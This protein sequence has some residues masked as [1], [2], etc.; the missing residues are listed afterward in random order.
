[1]GQAC[2][3]VLIWLTGRRTI[4]TPKTNNVP[5]LACIQVAQNCQK[6]AWVMNWPRMAKVKPIHPETSTMT[7]AIEA[8]LSVKGKMT[9]QMGQ[10]LTESSVDF[11]RAY[12]WSNLNARGDPTQIL[13]R[14]K[15]RP[16]GQHP[17]H[18]ASWVRDYLPNSN[19][20]RGD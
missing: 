16:L 15:Q 5:I 20:T 2:W 4:A 8:S 18:P 1:M 14:D 19:I 11:G 6:V 3:E 7:L 17:K 13:G 12:F 10:D 9:L